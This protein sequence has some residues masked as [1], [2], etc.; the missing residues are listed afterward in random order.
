MPIGP[1]GDFTSTTTSQNRIQDR[2]RISFVAGA[3]TA[4]TTSVGNRRLTDVSSGCD[5]DQISLT[6][7]IGELKYA[8][9]DSGRDAIFFD[10]PVS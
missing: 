6:S 7:Q 3:A 10:E 1:S 4:A 9:T 5:L 2:F 8:V